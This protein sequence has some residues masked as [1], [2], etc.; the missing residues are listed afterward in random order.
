NIMLGPYGETLVMDWGLAKR[1]EG[2]SAETGADEQASK[3]NSS[4]DDMTAIGAVLGT[5]Q[6]MSPE[7]ASRKPAGPAS[8]LFSLGVIL[9]A[10]LT[11]KSPYHES[12]A[13]GPL[14]PMRD[15]ALI[16]PRE[17][18][19]GIPRPLEAICLKAMAE[20]PEK[21]YASARV[22]AEDVARWLADEPVSAYRERLSARLA[23]WTRRHRA[24]VQAA[25]LALLVIAVLATIAA[26]VVDQ[27]RR[28]EGAARAEVTRALANER[29]AKAEAD[30]N[31]GL[32][33]RAV[34]D[35]FTKISENALLKRQDAA[36]VRD[37][38]SLRKELLEVALDY[39]D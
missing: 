12:P 8:D 29:A 25:A 34:D 23:R 27:A 11:A 6:Y 7:Q 14:K 20:H 15:A 32:A 30:E 37:L 39:Y 4:L 24:S 19:A 26:V 3:L 36:E 33:G 5:P 16:P 10:I 2:D 9:Y 28:R 35:Y 13:A 21:R 38:R 18:D 31:L 17:H 1:Y 22:L